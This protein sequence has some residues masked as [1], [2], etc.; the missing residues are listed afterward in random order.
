MVEPPFAASSQ[1]A[2][3]R[4][5]LLATKLHVPRP[6]PDL[7]P[8]L[9]LAERLDEGLACGRKSAASM[10]RTSRTMAGSTEAVALARELGLIR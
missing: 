7:V 9:R 6:R 10:R 5:V 1:V 8:R 4:D 3:E 2:S